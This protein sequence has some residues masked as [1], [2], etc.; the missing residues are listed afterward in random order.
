MTRY[1]TALVAGPE[2]HRNGP[3]W[4]TRVLD[5][6]PSRT[7]VFALPPERPTDAI[8]TMRQGTIAVGTDVRDLWFS[9]L[10]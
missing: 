10:R 1:G 5:A 9:R 2:V 6:C 8:T 7:H 3:R 4:S